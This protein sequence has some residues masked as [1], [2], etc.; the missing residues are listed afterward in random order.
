MTAPTAG[1]MHVMAGVM[2]DAQGR[3]LLAQRPPGKHLAG[4]WEFPGGKLEAGE[5]PAD[6]LVRELQEELGIDAA[7]GEPLIRVPWRY[8]ERS[9]LL[10]ARVVR[11]WRGQPA[12]LDGQA[13]RWCAPAAV[14]LNLLAPADRHILR[15]LQLPARYAIT[16]DVPV[17][18]TGEWSRRIRGAIA[19]GERMILLRFPQW[20][21]AQVRALAAELLPE[22]RDR[23]THLLL[24]G[25]V[26]GALA[27]G[28][29]VG[30]QLKAAQ[31]A[32][33][34]ARPLPLT[35]WV[36]AS[37]HRDDELEQA[38]EVADFATLSPVAATA[39]HPGVTPMGW[40]AFEARVSGSALPV[41]ALG[42]M[43]LALLD[44]ARAAGG[45]G[46]AGIRGFW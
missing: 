17:E 6:G 37:C 24:S 41:Y 22:A 36:G 9:L 13:L 30:V 43:S 8:G 46:V 44:T 42:G 40:A 32:T 34:H 20:P 29:G 21:V 12:S 18:E 33:F 4:L 10:D 7:I 26:D 1:A 28:E 27:L 14:D 19:A 23:G 31:L 15:A 38:Q 3:V 45:Q 39:T 11:S 2:L 35:Q 16:A 25:D 5:A